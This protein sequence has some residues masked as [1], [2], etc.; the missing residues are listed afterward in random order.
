MSQVAEDPNFNPD[1]LRAK[2]DE[3]RAKRVRSDGIRQYVEIKGK[4]EHYADD[5]H[6]ERVQRAPLHDEVDVLI[7]GGGWGGLTAAAKLTE[8]GVKDVR[9]IEHA[10]DFGGAWYWNRYPGLQCDIESYCYMPLLEET[11][12]MPS[13]KFVFQPEILEHAQR[14][15][16]HY[17]LYRLACF[18]TKIDELRWDDASEKWTITT[19]RGDRMQARF[20][21]ECIG[22]LD[23]PKLPGIADLDEFKG[24]AFH[25]SRWDYNYTGG[26]PTGGLTKLADKR[27]AIIGTGATSVQCVPFLGRDC[28][29]LLV[30]QRTPVSVR[31]R[32]NKLTDPEWA[33][34]L[35]PGWQRRRMENFNFIVGGGDPKEDLVQDGWTDMFQK[36]GALILTGRT[37]KGPGQTTADEIARLTEELDF[38]YMDET[39]NLIEEIVDDKATAESLKPWFRN[40]CKRPTFNDDYIATFNRPNVTLIDTDGRGVDRITEKGVVFDGKEY[41]VDCIIFASGFEYST[42]FVRRAGFETYGRG[43]KQLSDHWAGGMRTLHG[44]YSHGFPNLFHMGVTQ[45]GLALNFPHNLLEQAEHITAVVEH[46]RLRQKQ[47]LEP[48]PEAEADWIKTI[49]EKQFTNRAFLEGCTPGVLNGE[50][51][52]E[53]AFGATQYGGGSVD[54]WGIL[55]EWREGGDMPGLTFSDART[56]AKATVSAG[57]D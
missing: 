45:N 1:A 15:G 35:T 14:I 19:D 11:G 48:T 46:A 28:G 9:I 30:F 44:F 55:R 42:P 20:V 18:H 2:Y 36:L 49:R 12:Y 16:R 21:I 3:E 8:A 33:K 25:T 41:E 10:G 37:G 22:P 50:G 57:D 6:K 51:N 26:G 24:H 5:P 54:F 38:R 39:R 23:K 7:I 17:D 29:E 32:R 4:F 27:V 47:I 34:S 31:L 43:G 52:V 13:S 40:F 53:E 56:G